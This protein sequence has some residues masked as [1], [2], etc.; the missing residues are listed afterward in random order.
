MVDVKS[1]RTRQR[2]VYASLFVFAIFA[3]WFAFLNFFAGR[4]ALLDLG[5]EDHPVENLAALFWAAASAVCVY[6]LVRGQKQ[7]RLLLVF[8]AV[9]AFVF[10]GEETSWFQR[11]L[12]FQTPESV[13]EA[14][15]QGEFNLHNLLQSDSQRLFQLFF[16]GYFLV[17]PLL[18]LWPRAR[19][20]AGRVGYSAPHRAFV[21]TVWVVIAVSLLLQALGHE[22]ARRVDAESRETFYAFTVLAYVS[23]YLRP[24]RARRAPRA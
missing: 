2:V 16:L 24:G 11:V 7:S 23:L 21:V 14:N 13:A 5:A 20:W 17:L 1:E 22:E 18:M 3:S 9:A 19:A 8:W 15:L 4:Q 10:M 12:D 6:R